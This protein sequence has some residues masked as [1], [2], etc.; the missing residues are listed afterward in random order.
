MLDVLKSNNIENLEQLIFVCNIQTIFGTSLKRS[1]D[2]LEHQAVP[3]YRGAVTWFHRYGR[4][5][6]GSGLFPMFVAFETIRTAVDRLIRRF[7]CRWMCALD[8]YTDAPPLQFR[9]L[10]FGQRWLHSVG[11]VEQAVQFRHCLLLAPSS[12]RFPSTAHDQAIFV[13]G[14]WADSADYCCCCRRCWSRHLQYSA[15]PKPFDDA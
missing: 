15:I 10:A 7:Q 5:T 4:P 11:R 1:S 2:L 13:N 3:L 12:I 9:P 8:P 6:V 14:T